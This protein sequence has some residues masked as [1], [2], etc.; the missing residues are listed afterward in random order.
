M[1]LAAAVILAIF[2]VIGAPPSGPTDDPTIGPNPSA[3]PGIA[4]LSTPTGSPAAFDCAG[5]V[6]VSS[7]RASPVG[8]YVPLT[9]ITDSS[10]VE[11]ANA[12]LATALECHDPNIPN[13]R[14]SI[15][16][17]MVT[18]AT[19]DRIEAV[20]ASWPVDPWGVAESFDPETTVLIDID[21]RSSSTTIVPD[22][23][24][25]M[26]NGRYGAITYQ[27]SELSELQP[28]GE[29]F[30]GFIA[31]FLSFRPGE[32]A[33][34]APLVLTEYFPLCTDKGDGT[35]FCDSATYP[36]TEDVR[37]STPAATPSASPVASPAA[38]G[39][40][41]WLADPDAAACEL[42]PANPPGAVDGGWT[43]S[44]PLSGLLPF[45]DTSLVNQTAAAEVYL[46][47]QRCDGFSNPAAN[48]LVSDRFAG[49]LTAE[50]GD[51]PPEQEALARQ[52]S[53]AYANEDPTSFVIEGELLPA[54]ASSPGSFAGESRR[55]L[56]PDDVVQL[57]DGRIGGPAHVFF[58]TNAPAGVASVPGLPEFLETRFIVFTAEDGRWVID[59]SLLICIGQCDDDRTSRYPGSTPTGATPAT[60]DLASLGASGLLIVGDESDLVR[61]P[62][63][64]QAP[65]VLQQGGSSSAIP[66]SHPNVVIRDDGRGTQFAQNVST[67]VASKTFP[68]RNLISVWNVGP[69]RVIGYSDPVDLL[70]VDLRTM[71]LTSIAELNGGS[72]G[73]ND[74]LFSVQGEESGNL[75]VGITSADDP[76][77]TSAVA[78]FFDAD[79]EHVRV[80]EGWTASGQGGRPG[81]IA[82]DGASIAYPVSSDGS[83]VLRTET[84]A[85][86]PIRNHAWD[87]A[88]HIL[89]L[90]FLNPTDLIV[91]SAGT[92]VASPLPDG[93]ISLIH[94]ETDKP[95]IVELGAFSARTDIEGPFISPSGSSLLYATDG[96]IDG[97][98]APIW[99]LLDFQTGESREI[100]ELRGFASTLGTSEPVVRET[101]PFVGD[102][103][104]SDLTDQADTFVWTTFDLTTGELQAGT[105]LKTVER[106][107]VDS[108]D[109]SVVAGFSSDTPTRADG[110]GPEE[111]WSVRT[112]GSIVIVDGPT[113]TTYAKP[114]PGTGEEWVVPTLILS[115]D[116]EHIAFSVYG[117]DESTP[118]H[119][120]WVTSRE[121][122]VPWIE[123]GPYMI[124]DWVA[125][126]QR[127]ET[128]APQASS[129]IPA[130][131]EG[132]A[133]PADDSATTPSASDRVRYRRFSVASKVPPGPAMVDRAA[134][135]RGARRDR[136]QE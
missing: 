89:R 84:I 118:V 87:T 110:T 71:R 93:T 105:S 61:V 92:T 134:E 52:I 78:A 4:A 107:I 13:Q 136:S 55:V 40:E 12:T 79:G 132:E 59:D 15:P 72:I 123:V 126:T 35:T 83:L 33:A 127:K 74:P 24:F 2:R 116:G 17:I 46:Q 62:L 129:A 49:L 25:E 111:R 68:T 128:T 10:L 77:S 23:L 26:P 60:G 28:N 58:R 41:R 36:S 37:I 18:G 124:H 48:M 73:I 122:G 121:P 88:S 27:V 66:T 1:A 108:P 45:S 53:D 135:M 16:P 102:F 99:Y 112:D 6:T 30:L 9:H 47:A 42:D 14:N 130:V 5:P 82:P 3:N 125:P 22:S 85:G 81:A 65:E 64:G 106:H 54:S 98:A 50:S 19:R 96:E 39:S 56:L 115:P 8:A 114:L 32:G 29:P 94:P 86:E 34:E 20:R 76:G 119:R 80:L 38:R 91:F 131:I 11:E 31:V 51:I 109:H 69:Y 57:A 133:T 75:I 21:G 67:G 44:A 63:D 97:Q 70:V 100:P 95:V 103:P 117:S 90:A 113:D 101:I 7:G 104:N 43:G 120:T